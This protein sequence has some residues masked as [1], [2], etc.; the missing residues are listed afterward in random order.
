MM[1]VLE[2]VADG[3]R[4]LGGPVLYRSIIHSARLR[5]QQSILLGPKITLSLFLLFIPSVPFSCF[6][7]PVYKCPEINYGEKK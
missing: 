5:K 2:E 3:Q 1:E 6:P 7:R 4:L